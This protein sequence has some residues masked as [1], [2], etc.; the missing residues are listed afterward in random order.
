MIASPGAGDD[1]P[2][3]P[4]RLRLTAAGHDDRVAGHAARH[5]HAPHAAAQ[6]ELVLDDEVRE[7]VRQLAAAGRCRRER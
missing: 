4:S 3:A 7:V 1:L 6:P 5:D 2:A